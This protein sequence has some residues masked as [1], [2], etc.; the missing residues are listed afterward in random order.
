MSQRER[1]RPRDRYER[2]LLRCG[3]RL[4][5]GADE[6]GRGACAG[7]LVAAA[8]ILPAGR[9]GRIAGL[10]DSKLL[11]PAARARLFD[12][13]LEQA[14]AL[15]VVELPAPAVDRLGLQAANLCALR[16]AVAALTPPPDFA[17]VD[18][19]A[20]PGL[21]VPG[22]GVWKGDQVVA[23][24]AAASIL[25]KVT[26]DRRMSEL[27]LRWPG[28]GFAMHKGYCT[29]EHAAALA[30]LGPCPE[31]RRSYAPV[32]AA[33]RGSPVRENASMVESA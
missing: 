20:V 29:R 26:R 25:A 1:V 11:T 32:R 4:V 2:A 6:A 14:A 9:H 19:F 3:F 16:R 17:L 7:P 28:Y 13:V 33:L 12:A 21:G 10:A 15:A 22:L 8:C 23:S 18:G 24:V 31:H 27:D 5:A 30:S